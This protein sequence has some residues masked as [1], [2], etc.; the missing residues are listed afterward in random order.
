MSKKFKDQMVVA[1]GGCT[2]LLYGEIGE[3]EDVR[4][5]DITRELLQAEA[6]YKNIDVRINSIGGEVYAGIA[7]FNA[8]KNCKAD[9]RIFIDGIA[10]S[11]ASVIALCGRHVEMSRYARLMLHSPYGGCWGN[12]SEM[13]TCISDLEALEDTLCAMC[14]KRIGLT[15]EEVKARYFDGQDHWLTAQQALDAGFIDAIYDAQPVPEDQTI[16]QLYTTFSNRLNKPQTTTDMSL[17]ESIKKSARFKDCSADEDVLKIVGQL[18]AKAVKV[19]ALEAENAALKKKNEDFEA[20]AKE[21]AA[22]AKKALLDAAEADGRIDVVS[23][24]A[25]QALLDSDFEAGKKTIDAL[26]PKRRAI[27]DVLIDPSGDE[28]PWEKKM[29]EIKDRQKKRMS[30]R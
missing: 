11:M 22:K 2:I 13:A 10:A 21:E 23:R 8:L 25:Y 9:V 17:F 5:T 29:S 28:S 4:S 26:K 24:P 15:E 16:E 6:T 3:Y 30:E 18:E 20:K 14:A 7:I 12:K 27:E 19:D 1:G